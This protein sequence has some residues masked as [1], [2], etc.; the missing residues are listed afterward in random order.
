MPRNP[1]TGVYTQ[2]APDVVAGTTIE[3]KV[4]NDFV[5]DVELDLNTARPIIA[6]GT[7]ADDAKEARDNLDAEVA[8]AQVT[9]YGTQVWESGSFYSLT[10][11]TA[12]PVAGHAFFGTA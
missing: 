3:S 11:A 12:P 1:G 8:M 2:P 7:G 10:S 6:G 9:D 4:Y 5:N